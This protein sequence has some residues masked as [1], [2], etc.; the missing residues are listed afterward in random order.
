MHFIYCQLKEYLQKLE[1]EYR[2][3]GVFKIKYV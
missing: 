3:T 1:V 2:R